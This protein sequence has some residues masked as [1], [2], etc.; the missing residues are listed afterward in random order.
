M[1]LDNLIDF[2]VRTA[3]EAGEITLRHF[4]RVATERKSDGSEV[5][6]ALLADF[7]A[8]RVACLTIGAVDIRPG[9]G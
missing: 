9:G 8:R 1:D 6:A 3:Q 5:T 7:G 4:G 2:A